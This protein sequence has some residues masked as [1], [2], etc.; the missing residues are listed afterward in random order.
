[1][2]VH[3]EVILGI[4]VRI[5]FRDDG[6][7]SD[8]M[9]SSSLLVLSCPLDAIP[10]CH[11]GYLWTRYHFPCTSGDNIPSLPLGHTHH[12]SSHI[13]LPYQNQ[14]CLSINMK[15][16]KQPRSWTKDLM[17]LSP[18]HHIVHWEI[19]HKNMQPSVLLYEVACPRITL[20]CH[21]KIFYQSEFIPVIYYAHTRYTHIHTTPTLPPP[22]PC[23]ILFF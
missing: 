14:S 19:Y 1:M 3:A 7:L 11:Y 22:P 9:R 15:G 20:R 16:I 4:F 10:I 2:S 8:S 13:I 12:R 17:P 21:I 6:K 5:L 18:T 23:W